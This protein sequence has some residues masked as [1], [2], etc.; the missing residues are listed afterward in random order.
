MEVLTY[1]PEDKAN[2]SLDDQVV[3]CSADFYKAAVVSRDAFKRESESWPKPA[4]RRIEFNFTSNHPDVCIKKDGFHLP[5]N[6][7]KFTKLTFN[8]FDFKGRPNLA[9]LMLF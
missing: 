9:N 3:L 4:E 1:I 8:D 6:R 5:E 2:T 7:F